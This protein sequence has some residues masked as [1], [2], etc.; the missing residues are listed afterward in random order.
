MGMRVQIRLVDL[1]G[2]PELAVRLSTTVEGDAQNRHRSDM[3]VVVDIA[4]NTEYMFDVEP[5]DG[6][7]F[8][9]WDF[10]LWGSNVQRLMPLFH[11]YGI[12]YRVY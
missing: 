10:N 9:A 12:P 6:E 4:T 1:L 5:F 3:A 11:N 8:L 2:Q 7:V